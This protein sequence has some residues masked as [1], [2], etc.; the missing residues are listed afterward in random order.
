MVVFDFVWA[1][2]II[3]SRWQFENARAKQKMYTKAAWREAN[4]L[5]SKSNGKKAFFVSF[6]F[7]KKLELCRVFRASSQ[8][9][10]FIFRAW[11]EHDTIIQPYKKCII[12]PLS[13]STLCHESRVAD[14]LAECTFL[15][16][17]KPIRPQEKMN[18]WCI[19]KAWLII[20]SF[21]R[22][23]S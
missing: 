19:L 10:F 4:S 20:R 9:Y 17:K 23:S 12:V 2:Q 22:E 18:D 1:Q 3:Q 16:R 7:G 21:F 14:Y 5:I 11:L 6:L 8:P 13:S 15:R